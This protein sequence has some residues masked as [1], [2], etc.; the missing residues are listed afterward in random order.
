MPMQESS[1]ALRSRDPNARPV[2]ASPA[3]ANVP[4][5]AS[6][7]PV[8]SIPRPSART[9]G[10]PPVAPTPT[11]PTPATRKPAA[12]KPAASKPAAPRPAASKV[13]AKRASR[14]PAEPRSA[15]KVKLDEEHD[16]DD[17][18]FEPEAHGE[19]E[20]DVDEVGENVVDEQDPEMLRFVAKL[21]EE[22]LTNLIV[23]YPDSDSDDEYI[24]D[25]LSDLEVDD[26]A[27]VSDDDSD[28]P[29][30]EESLPAPS[31]HARK[32]RK[33]A[34]LKKPKPVRVATGAVEDASPR[35]PIDVESDMARQDIER[36]REG[37]LALISAIR[38]QCL[39]MMRKYGGGYNELVSST[40]LGSIPM[41]WSSFRFFARCDPAAIAR[42]L[43]TGISLDVQAVFG[44]QNLTPDGLWSLPP[45]DKT[46][47]FG[48]YL[49]VGKTATEDEHGVYVGSSVNKKDGIHSRVRKHRHVANYGPKCADERASGHYRFM[50][51][52]GIKFQFSILARFS[53]QDPKAPAL[54][55]L[56]EA[57]MMAYLNVVRKRN[58]PNI[59]NKAFSSHEGFR[60]IQTSRHGLGL[61]DMQA[62]GLNWTWNMLQGEMGIPRAILDQPCWVC[63]EASVHLSEPG[64]VLGRRLC[65]KHYVSLRW[66]VSDVWLSRGPC[67]RCHKPRELITSNFAGEEE[68]SECGSCIARI[69]YANATGKPVPTVEEDAAAHCGCQNCHLKE[70]WTLE[71]AYIDKNKRDRVP[72][73]PADGP[74]DGCGNPA[75]R[76]P[77]NSGVAFVK[78]GSARRCRP[79]AD[80]MKRPGTK[81]ERSRFQV[82]KALFRDAKKNGGRLS[83]DMWAELCQGHGWTGCGMCGK[84]DVTQDEMLA[85]PSGSKGISR[86]G[87]TG[88]T[89][90]CATCRSRVEREKAKQKRVCP[91]TR[92]EELDVGLGLKDEDLTGKLGS[93]EGAAGD[94]QK[95]TAAEGDRANGNGW[96]EGQIDTVQGSTAGLASL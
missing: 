17:D 91:E 67:R 60:F 49:N 95:V 44:R 11:A 34:N 61:P 7:A 80:H 35:E 90:R 29:G 12:P 74:D 5:A 56:A 24:D 42:D 25:E 50:A 37:M 26:P 18:A 39:A 6:K 19:D 96:R 69:E 62:F 89:R 46:N 9:P 36:F 79:C 10:L 4:S 30:G 58:R 27:A 21:Q 63:G 13:P 75:C 1:R 85:L 8:T 14:V 94:G 68:T 71:W 59:Q 43:L 15:K 16:D 31:S 88:D 32:A 33:P 48:C 73:L 64:D 81:D 93:R 76:A 57:M 83:D 92:R 55:R 70:W 2:P 51:R 77:E 3:Q 65:A 28:V 52:P 82:L 22:D 87:G 23:N 41:T 54:T 53:S 38:E 78:H 47:D 86:I 72:K 20:D 84:A 45:A 66:R 40:P